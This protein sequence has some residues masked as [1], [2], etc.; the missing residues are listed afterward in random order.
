MKHIRALP[1]LLSIVISLPGHQSSKISSRIITAKRICLS[2]SEC[3]PTHYC[4]T[5]TYSI[6]SFTCVP[7]LKRN[8]QCNIHLDYQCQRRFYCSDKGSKSGVRRC[9]QGST[10]NES[11]DPNIQQSCAGFPY[12]TCSR[13]S[14][15][16]IQA[17]VGRLDA[18]C[19]SGACSKSQRLYCNNLVCRKQHSLGGDCSKYPDSCDGSTYCDN[20]FLFTPKFMFQK[21]MC[22]KTSNVGQKCLSDR[23]CKGADSVCIIQSGSYGKCIHPSQRITK[24]GSSCNT[25]LDTCDRR[26]GLSCQRFQGRYVCMQRAT[27]RSNFRYWSTPYYTPNNK[28]S[29]CMPYFGRPTE[30]RILS[31]CEQ[32]PQCKDAARQQAGTRTT[33]AREYIIP[34]PLFWSCLAE[35]KFLRQ[36]ALCNIQENEICGPGLLC[37]FVPSV[38]DQLK[39]SSPKRMG[40]CVKVI[41]QVNG[42]CSDPF[43]TKCET[44]MSCVDGR[45]R[46]GRQS[47][48]FNAQQKT[49]LGTHSVD[50]CDTSKLPCA[51]GLVCDKQSRRCDRP[52]KMVKKGHVCY[53]I[54][55][56][57]VV[58][59]NFFKFL[60]ILFVRD[61]EMIFHVS[62]PS[63]HVC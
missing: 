25:K 44:G 26:R 31:S 2:Q 51:P 43:Q 62:R 16:C 34:T 27:Y 28:F 42:V 10:R 57:R 5:D 56:F 15:T 58:S 41:K 21:A 38:T 22:L 40:H 12:D 37:H 17:N 9:Q 8:D 30:C 11:C 50:R 55:R 1:P 46:R 35:R 23:Q 54:S 63:D 61:L 49:H 6:S 3:P 33:A 53:D 32:F 29:Q 52:K 4:N 36:G 20:P 45:C 14:K 18:K 39:Y 7:L 47:F 59:F 48:K 60:S 19:K 24:P 13:D